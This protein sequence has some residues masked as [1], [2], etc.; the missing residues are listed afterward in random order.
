MNRSIR[1][2]VKYDIEGVVGDEEAVY[3]CGESSFFKADGHWRSGQRF[4]R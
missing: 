2:L 4:M 1:K 3:E